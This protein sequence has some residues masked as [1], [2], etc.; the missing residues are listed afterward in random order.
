MNQLLK[1]NEVET[2]LTWDLTSLFNSQE[3]MLETLAKAVALGNDLHNKFQGKL[4]DAQSI[5]A[6]LREWIIVLEKAD[7]TSTYTELTLATDQTNSEATKLNA[8]VG[9]TIAKFYRKRISTS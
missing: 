7:Q 6:C 9:S 1:R 5:V 4:K 2:S 3:K 8:H